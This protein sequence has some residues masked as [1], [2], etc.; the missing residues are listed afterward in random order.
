MTFSHLL[1]GP[2]LEQ[3]VKE[4]E[5]KEV[6]NFGKESTRLSKTVKEV[7]AAILPSMANVISVAVVVAVSTVVKGI[8]DKLLMSSAESEKS[9][10]IIDTTIPS[11]SNIQ[12]KTT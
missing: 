4:K 6:D 7:G 9:V 2:S 11:W 12:E 1:K 3:L 8:T 10:Y 5:E